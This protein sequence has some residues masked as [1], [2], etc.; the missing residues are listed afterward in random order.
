MN[1]WYEGKEDVLLS[2]EIRLRGEFIWGSNYTFLVDVADTGHC[3]QAVYKPTRG[4]RNLWDFPK[5]SLARREVAAYLVSNALGWNLVPPTIYREEAPLG[6]GSLQ[7]FIEHNPEY[8]YF[9]FRP[10]HIQLLRPTVLFDIVI[11][12]ADRKGSHI[13]FD[14]NQHLWLI[15]HG[16]CF[17][18]EEKL[19]TVIWD[20]AG[21]EIPLDLLGDLENFLKLLENQFDDTTSFHLQ[22]SSYLTQ[23][24]IQA[25]KFRLAGLINLGKFPFPDPNRRNYPWPEI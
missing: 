21:Q 3:F 18:A 1:K 24:E 7:L 8:H 25:M 5:S 11:N 9:N 20:F 10:E 16:I 13:I 4:T 17:H 6:T 12:N 14:E 23:V 15:D 2:G 22:L 19:R